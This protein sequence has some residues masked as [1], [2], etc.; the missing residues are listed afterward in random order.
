MLRMHACMHLCAC[1]FSRCGV[2]RAGLLLL[3][4]LLRARP[5]PLAAFSAVAAAPAVAARTTV[6]VVL[7]ACARAYVHARAHT[8]AHAHTHTHTRC[9]TESAVP[10]AAGPRGCAG[11]GPPH[12]GTYV[13]GGGRRRRPRRPRGAALPR[14]I[15]R[16]HVQPARG[17]GGR[18]RL[19]GWEL[20]GRPR[21]A[22]SELRY[23]H[24]FAV[25]PRCAPALLRYVV[26]V[27]A[28]ARSMR[29]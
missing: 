21:R 1:V 11:W 24:R 7:A 15:R 3:L 6:A 22:G 29:R 9:I 19:A 5:P 8:H 23:Q 18:P 13:G 17:G 16:R 12:A 2:H 28:A 10:A 25:L 27:C 14:K 26:R 4:L 20:R